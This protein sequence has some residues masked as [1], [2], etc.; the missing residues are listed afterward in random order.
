MEDESFDQLRITRERGHRRGSNSSPLGQ[1]MSTAGRQTQSVVAFLSR[2]R[3][4]GSFVWALR[5]CVGHVIRPTTLPPRSL[6]P[7]K[8]PSNAVASSFSTGC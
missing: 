4:C 3:G 5:H 1:Q 8:I 2:P 7:N 6:F